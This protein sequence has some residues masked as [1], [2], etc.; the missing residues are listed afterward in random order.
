MSQL[1]RDDW[2]KNFMTRLGRIK[3][4][5]TVSVYEDIC[6]A[7]DAP[8]RYADQPCD[9]CKHDPQAGRPRSPDDMIDPGKI[10]VGE[11]VACKEPV[12][13]TE[14]TKV[15][16]P[17]GVHYECPACFCLHTRQQFVT[18]TEQN[19]APASSEGKPEQ[20]HDGD[21]AEWHPGE[22]DAS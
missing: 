10:E 13:L 22:G 15:V 19:H 16:T 7:C 8:K 2:L 17:N 5:E 18:I 12:P 11:C 20:Q 6:P 21:T 4:E 3:S 14:E 1:G 9:F